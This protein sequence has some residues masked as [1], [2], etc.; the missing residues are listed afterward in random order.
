MKKYNNITVNLTYT[1]LVKNNSFPLTSPLLGADYFREKGYT[2][3]V[4]GNRL[5]IT[6]E[7]ITW[8]YAVSYEVDG[9]DWCKERSYRDIVDALHRIAQIK[10]YNVERYINRKTW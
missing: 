5:I 2:A 8:E 4:V 7:Y 3:K 1:E 6:G 9:L 10:L